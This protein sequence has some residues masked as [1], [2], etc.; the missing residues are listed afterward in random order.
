[1]W[2][3]FAYSINL[4]LFLYCSLIQVYAQDTIPIPLKVKI[5]LEVSGPAIYYSDKSILNEE[6]YISVDLNEKRSVILDIGHLNYKYSQYNYSY[7]SNGNFVKIGIDFNLLSADKSLGKYYAGIG[8]RY[9][10]S[11]FFR[12]FQCYKRQITGAQPS[13]Q[14]LRA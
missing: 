7:L 12:K 13:L 10:L 2:R 1:M 6:G 8:F 5:G 4:L 3:I 11:R 9:G 14:F